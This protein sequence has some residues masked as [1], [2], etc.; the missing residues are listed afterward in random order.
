MR[1]K[2]SVE[3]LIQYIRQHNINC[4]CCNHNNSKSICDLYKKYNP[5]IDTRYYLPARF[6]SHTQ[7]ARGLQYAIAANAIPQYIIE[8]IIELE[9]ASL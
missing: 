8:E 7:L 1:D 5:Y 2:F 9:I 3:I 6:F 4:Y